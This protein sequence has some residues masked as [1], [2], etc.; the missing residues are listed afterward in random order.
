[1]GNCEGNRSWPVLREALRNITN[2]SVRIWAIR[3]ENRTRDVQNTKW[4][5]NRYTISFG[6]PLPVL[7]VVPILQSVWVIPVTKFVV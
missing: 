4:N 7:A 5:A 6:K 3:T 2:A 1:M